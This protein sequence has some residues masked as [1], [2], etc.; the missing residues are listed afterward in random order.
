MSLI[1][2]ITDAATRTTAGKYPVTHILPGSG[3]HEARGTVP[4]TVTFILRAA[5]CADGI[6][7]QTA[8]CHTE[9][10]LLLSLVK[11]SRFQL[12]QRSR[13]VIPASR[14]MRSSSAGQT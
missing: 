3:F 5:S 7:R 10:W 2:T 12:L 11:G 4:A 14:A 13:R 6:H 1:P 9:M 8:F